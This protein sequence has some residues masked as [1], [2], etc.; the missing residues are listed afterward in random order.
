MTCQL[1]K[2]STQH[3][4]RGTYS[5]HCLDCAARYLLATYP[6]G[7][8]TDTHR[9]MYLRHRESLRYQLSKL[10]GVAYTVEQ[11]E[12]KAKEMASEAKK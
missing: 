2:S 12:A 3:A 6:K 10:K 8:T 5:F 11:A 9:M 1:C 7:K 4:A